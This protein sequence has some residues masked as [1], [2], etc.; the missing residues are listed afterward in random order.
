MLSSLVT[1]PVI[2][3]AALSLFGK[4]PPKTVPRPLTPATISDFGGGLNAIDND[5]TMKTRFA[6]VLRNMNKNVDGSMGKRWGTKYFCRVDAAVSGTIIEQMYFRKHII[7]VMSSGEVAKITEAGVVTAI[8]NTAIAAAL[9]G[10]P[11]AWSAALE[12]GS[13]DFTE[14][15]GEMVV[16]N[17][18]DKPIIIAKDLTVEYL[19]DPSTGSNINV[20]ISRYVTTVS[21]YVVMAGVTGAEDDLYISNQGTSG[22]WFG[23]PDPNDAVVISIGTYVPQ[24]SGDILGIGS[25]RNYLLVAFEGAVVVVEL[26]TY[27]GDDHK[28][29]IQDNIVE[30]GIISHRTTMTTKNDFVMAD[31]LGWHTALR[32]QFGLIDTKGLS[33]LVDPIF[34]AAVPGLTVDRKKCFSV[35]NPLENRFMTFVYDATGPVVW[36]MTSADKE[37]IKSPAWNTYTDMNWTSGCTSERGR[38]FLANGV[39]LFQY[40]NGVYEGEDFSADLVDD[41]DAEWATAT[42]YTAGDKVWQDDAAYVAETTHVSDAFAA[43]LSAGKWARYYGEEIDFDWE[44]PWS[45]INAR[46][47]KKFLKMVQ[48]DT[49]GAAAFDLDIF[50]DNYY[51]DEDDNYDPALTMGFVAGDSPGYG[52]G[53]QPYGGGRRLRD[54][55][56]WQ[57]PGEFKIMKLR[58]SGSSREALKIISLTIMYWIGNIRR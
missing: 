46:A 54:E 16:V 51:K 50:F 41:H 28:P 31:V 15:R 55:R 37:Q 45:A 25:F 5:I 26:G 7:V 8:W 40:G 48:A 10:T 49:K 1:E 11:S 24:N 35:R 29:S 58:I 21:N 47:L 2:A 17:G 34:I 6:K 19:N 44:F 36:T 18:V 9:V 23:D 27:S 20:P 42:N 57:M 4:N 43:D 3:M 13:I 38:V 33:E 32:T 52:G 14:F 30:H 12:L 39:K 22:V 53:D 56:P